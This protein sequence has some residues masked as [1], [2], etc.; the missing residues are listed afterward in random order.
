[1]TVSTKLIDYN[2]GDTSLEGF[3]AFD[4]THSMPMQKNLPDRYEAK[5]RW[6]IRKHWIRLRILRN[7]RYEKM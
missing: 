2:D 5:Q 6:Q 3:F 4:D 7:C 1:M